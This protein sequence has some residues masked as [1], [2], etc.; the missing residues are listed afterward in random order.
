MEKRMKIGMLLRLHCTKAKYASLQSRRNREH[1]V[2]GRRK[3]YEQKD[4]EAV[5]DERKWD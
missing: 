3:V 4:D 1:R 5:R 2:K